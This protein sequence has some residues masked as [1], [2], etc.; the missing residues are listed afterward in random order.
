[1]GKPIDCEAKGIVKN[2]MKAALLSCL[3]FPGAGHVYLKRLTLGLLLSVGSAVALYFVVSNAVQA[4]LEV[5]EQIQEPGAPL[6]VDAILEL[7]S[8]QSRRAEESSRVAIIALFVLWFIGI[9]DSYRVGRA[10]D[11]RKKVAGEKE[12]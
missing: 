10:L 3:V 2:S 1:M 4:A 7:V 8:Q 11:N 12:N 6:G 5:A 9:F